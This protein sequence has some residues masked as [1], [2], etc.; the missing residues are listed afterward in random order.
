MLV[1]QCC[2]AL[3]ADDEYDIR[4]FDEDAGLSHGH[5]SQIL[6]DND[7]FLWIATWNGLNRF[8][9]YE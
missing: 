8:D 4:Q 9:G 5:A 3:H 6:Q 7:G 1:L 2:L